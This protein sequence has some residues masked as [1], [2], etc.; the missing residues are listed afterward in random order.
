MIEGVAVELDCH[1]LLDSR[2]GYPQRLLQTFEDTFAILMRE[3]R[4]KCQGCGPSS[5]GDERDPYR[6][7]CVRVFLTGLRLL[8]RFPRALILTIRGFRLI[9]LLPPQMACQDDSVALMALL[10]QLSAVQ[11]RLGDQ[12]IV[13][14]HSEDPGTSERADDE[15]DGL[16]LCS[17]LGDVIL[18]RRERLHVEVVRQVLEAALVG[19]LSGE[20][21]KPQTDVRSF[22]IGAEDGGEL[23]NKLEDSGDFCSPV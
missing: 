6:F 20:K 15:G 2:V 10:Q 11:G 19:D 14:L 5:L 22:D 1:D 18:V 12:R 16:Q 4:E 9:P 8:R 13:V 3:L 17:A 7:D 23:S 21:E